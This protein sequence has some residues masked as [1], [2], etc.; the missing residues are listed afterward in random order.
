MHLRLKGP[1]LAL[2]TGVFAWAGFP[3]AGALGPV[4]ACVA[5]APLFAALRGARTRRAFWLG[6]VAGATMTG[7]GF[8]FLGPAAAVHG[9][10]HPALVGAGYA[11]LTGYHA[12]F[13]ALPCAAAAR[14]QAHLPLAVSLPVLLATAEVVLPAPLPWAFGASLLEVGALAPS[15]AVFG[16]TGLSL[17]AFLI[18]G[19]GAELLR[20][21]R[22]GP[23]ARAALVVTGLYVIG[24]T[25]A[26][27]TISSSFSSEVAT[28]PRIRVGALHTSATGAP[29][30]RRPSEVARRAAGLAE[31][32]ADIVVTPETALAGTWPEASLTSGPVWALEPSGA[33]LIAGAAVRGAGRLSNTALAIDGRGELL[34][35]YDK[36]HLLP[37]AEGWPL[38][39]ALRWVSPRSGTF[40]PGTRPAVV[41]LGVASVGVTICLEDALLEGWRSPGGAEPDLVV[42][43]TN[44][45]WFAGSS[46][47]DAHLALARLRAVEHG[48]YL[49][50]ATAGGVTAI[51]DPSGRLLASLVP[52]DDGEL[53]ADVPQL[54]GRTPFARFGHAP[55]ALASVLLLALASWISRAASA[56]S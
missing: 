23:R 31:Q 18:A 42:N 27:M 11:L 29:S 15:A 16:G 22:G 28:A 43:L 3:P 41:D 52:E 48:R 32:G 1:A 47:P 20:P 40:S 17:A 5:F 39:E 30:A 37:L 26:G 8:S 6:L 55:L 35:R 24:A 38:P 7:L 33:I 44:D 54:R 53:L 51:V 36:R 13:V 56:P 34:A 12:L 4:V 2:A 9:G 19:A 46:E 14:L 25:L 21:S 45:S 50:R 10:L 49:V